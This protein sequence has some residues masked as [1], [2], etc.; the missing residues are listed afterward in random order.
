MYIILNIDER[1]NISKYTNILYNR[2]I[3]DSKNESIVIDFSAFSKASRKL[4]FVFL[5]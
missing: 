4:R 5:A 3:F 2:F 1:M